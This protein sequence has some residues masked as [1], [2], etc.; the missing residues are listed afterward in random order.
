MTNQALKSP[1]PGP[2]SPHSHAVRARPPRLPFVPHHSPPGL[3]RQDLLLST[4]QATRALEGR[5][6]HG[7]HPTEVSLRQRIT[8]WV[9]AIERGEA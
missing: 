8:A 3:S 4:A 6:R 1:Q 7:A 2:S 9:D 5:G